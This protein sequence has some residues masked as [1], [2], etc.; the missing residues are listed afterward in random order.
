M[1]CVCVLRQQEDGKYGI[2]KEEQNEKK[3]RQDLTFSE[4]H[5]PCGSGKSSFPKVL[6]KSL[7]FLPLLISV[8]H[9][10]S[11]MPLLV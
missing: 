9:S 5:P 1:S 2:L 6:V 8:S 3:Q 4:D 10:T 7:Q 11:T